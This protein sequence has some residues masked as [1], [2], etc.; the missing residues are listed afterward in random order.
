MTILL[1]D[2]V[3]AFHYVELPGRIGNFL[4]CVKDVGGRGILDYRFRY[5]KGDQSKN[6][7]ESEDVS[8][9]YHVETASVKEL[10]RVMVE[11]SNEIFRGLTVQSILRKPGE[12]LDAFMERF[13]Q[14][15]FVMVKIKEKP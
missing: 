5:Y 14:Q 4:A 3:Q 11:M 12:S 1:D 10:A 7:E 6:F 2:H 8:S 9:W 13:Q 15:P